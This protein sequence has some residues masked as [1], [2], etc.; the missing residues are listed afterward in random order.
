VSRI[1]RFS[2]FHAHLEE[3]EAVV[4]AV[5]VLVAPSG[6][7]WRNRAA[8]AVGQ[9]WSATARSPIFL[10]SLIWCRPRQSSKP[11]SVPHR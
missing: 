10:F 4:A 11:G 7:R 9:N 8:M 5:L 6:T 3:N 2:G 1:T